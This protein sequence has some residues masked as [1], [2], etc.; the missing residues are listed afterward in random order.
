MRNIIF[1]FLYLLIFLILFAVSFFGLMS[2][3]VMFQFNEQ[4][5]AT[6]G[7]VMALSVIGI[8]KTVWHIF[9]Y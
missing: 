7:L 5:P 6:D 2:G 4:F 9:K 3:Q 8:I 1:L